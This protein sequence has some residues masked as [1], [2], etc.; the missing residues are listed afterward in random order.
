MCYAD[1]TP[2]NPLDGS[3]LAFPCAGSPSAELLDCGGDDYFSQ[4]PA[5]GSWLAGHWNVAGSAFLCS[6]SKCFAALQPPAVTPQP[7]SASPDLFEPVTFAATQVTDDGPAPLVEWEAP[8]AFDWAVA[9]DGRSATVMWG[10]PGARTVRINLT[11]SDG[12]RTTATIPVT[13]VSKPPSAAIS[14]PPAIVAGHEVVLTARDEAGRPVARYQWDLDGA[15]GFERDSGANAHVSTTFA[16]PGP[17][18][19]AVRLTDTG[20]AAAEARAVLGVLPADGS[21]VEAGAAKLQLR[22]APGQSRAAR[23]RAL[24]LR[25]R[26]AVPGAVALRVAAG[27]KGKSRLLR[28]TM[29]VS[30]GRWATVR[31]TLPRRARALRWARVLQVTATAAKGARAVLVVPIRR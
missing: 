11:D 1:G 3:G 27:R 21:E 12:N 29:S 17:R 15:P 23:R 9:P 13:V 30:A 31:L 25:V 8:D 16:A 6:L 4:S 7:A 18:A 5:P 2:A 20:G 14:A 10:T 19:V 26:S 24:S 28:R 22:L